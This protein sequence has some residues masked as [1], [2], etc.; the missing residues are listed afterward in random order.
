[1]RMEQLQVDHHFLSSTNPLASADQRDAERKAIALTGTPAF[2]KLRAAI[3]RR[4]RELAGSAP[5][6]EAWAR[7]ET[8]I[9]ECAFANVMKA[10]NGDP[11]RPRVTRIVMPP[12]DWFGRSQ[13]HVIRQRPFHELD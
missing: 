10:V 4:W 11:S 2:S 3:A 7:F 8:L 9:D 1:M 6:K 13:L 5:T 12:H